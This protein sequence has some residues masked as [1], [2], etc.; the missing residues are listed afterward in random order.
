LFSA[1]MTTKVQK[2][3]RASLNDAVKIEVNT[4]YKTVDTLEQSYLFR[5]AK[6]KDTYLVYLVN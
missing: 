5:P 2:L 4:K 3:Q 1:T 6:Y